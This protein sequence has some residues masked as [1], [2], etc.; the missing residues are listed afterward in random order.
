[1][2]WGNEALIPS[3]G[4]KYINRSIY[5]LLDCLTLDH[6]AKVLCFALQAPGKHIAVTNNVMKGFATEL[7]ASHHIHIQN[8]LASTL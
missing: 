2:F 8:S 5:H 3:L 1:M 4:I 7:F 6:I